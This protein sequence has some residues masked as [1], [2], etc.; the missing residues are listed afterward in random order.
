MRAASLVM[1][2]RSRLA[3]LADLDPLTKHPGYAPAVV[4]TRTILPAYHSRARAFRWLMKSTI[5]FIL[6]SLC[7]ELDLDHDYSH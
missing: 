7:D 2:W 1:I 5:T 4:P 3:S 6:C